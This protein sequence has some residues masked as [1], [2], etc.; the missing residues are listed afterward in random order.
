MPSAD[1]VRAAAEADPGAAA[2]PFAAPE[3]WAPTEGALVRLRPG[4]DEV[5]GLR[6]GEVVAVT[7]VG[8]VDVCVKRLR[9]G[10]PEGNLINEIPAADL[11]HRFDGWLPA[12]A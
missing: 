2:W 9:D 3:G 5:E 12:A 6:A 8:S 10:K 1:A 7:A 11:V 4:L